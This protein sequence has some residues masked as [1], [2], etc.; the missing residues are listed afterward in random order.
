[1][2]NKPYNNFNYGFIKQTDPRV[3]IAVLPTEAN[4]LNQ[5]TIKYKV[6]NGPRSEFHSNKG[7]MEIKKRRILEEGELTR[8][9]TSGAE[10]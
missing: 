2:S 9:D 7:D 3:K 10:R 1:M 6:D 8:K 4:Q 5:K